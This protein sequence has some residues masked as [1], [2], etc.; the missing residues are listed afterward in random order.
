MSDASREAARCLWCGAPL[1]SSRQRYCARPR[2]CRDQ[3]YRDRR[4]AKALM[5]ERGALARAGHRL[6]H[7]LAE[8]REVLMQ[9]VVQEA[10]WPGVFALAAARIEERTADLVHVCIIAERAAGTSWAEVGEAFGIS[11]D[12]ARKRWGHWKLAH[13]EESSADPTNDS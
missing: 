2:L 12:A 11:A 7:Y 3:A 5:P 1:V 8:T 9:A 13:R 6:D 4:R 10:T